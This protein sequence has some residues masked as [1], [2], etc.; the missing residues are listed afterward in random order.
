MTAD[1]QNDDETS[2]KTTTGKAL[3]HT[4]LND[5]TSLIEMVYFLLLRV[6]KVP[7]E[8]SSQYPSPPKSQKQSSLPAAHSQ[9]NDGTMLRATV[10]LSLLVVTAAPVASCSEGQQHE[11]IPA[12]QVYCAPLEIR[13]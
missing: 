11:L 4:L 2:R 6:E 10:A 1:M 8:A 9:H 12:F 3:S 13:R 5:Q 7:P